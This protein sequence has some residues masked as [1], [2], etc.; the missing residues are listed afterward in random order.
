[1]LSFAQPPKANFQNKLRTLRRLVVGSV[2]VCGAVLA[3]ILALVPVDESVR[4]SGVVQAEVDTVLYAPM[5][6]VI[7]KLMVYEGSCVA[8]GDPLLDLD[9]TELKQKLRETEAA[10]ARSREALE[11]EMAAFERARQLPLPSQFWHVQEELSIIREKIRQSKVELQRATE[12]Q[13]SGLLS[14][15]DVERAQ[16]AL[17]INLSEEDKV[18]DKLR[19]IEGGMEDSVLGEFTARLQKARADIRAMEVTRDIT[20]ETIER[21]MIRAPDQ[22]TVTLVVKRRPGQAVD[23]GDDL[24]HLSHG[25]KLEADLLAGEEEF[26][27]VKAG[28]RVRMKTQAF[29]PLKYGYIEGVVQRVAKEANSESASPQAVPRFRV[30]ASIDST[31]QPLIIGS[32]IEATIILRRVPLWRLLLPETESL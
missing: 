1:M 4:A 24:M 25:E 28:Q 17:N 27:R 15:Q 22:G 26:H 12:M 29:N 2:V 31:P 32:S 30:V 10:V 8:K 16:L 7:G 18:E 14:K 23:K 6:G 21:C 19:L 9:T 5:D 13:S 3:G 20:R 11:A